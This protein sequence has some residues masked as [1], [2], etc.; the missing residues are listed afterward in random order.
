MC[1]RR[2]KRLTKLGLG[3]FILS[4]LLGWLLYFADS[5]PDWMWCPIATIF[6]SL[7]LI[8]TAMCESSEEK[9][10]QPSEYE[11]MDPIP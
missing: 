11:P 7:V 8:G 2:I 6:V 4:H 3:L 10:R 5:P 1:E 9:Y